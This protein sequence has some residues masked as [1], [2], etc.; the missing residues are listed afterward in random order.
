MRNESYC[1]ELLTQNCGIVYRELMPYDRILVT[2]SL[3]DGTSV[4]S[5]MWTE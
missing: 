1:W 4:G 2:R 5:N 3:R